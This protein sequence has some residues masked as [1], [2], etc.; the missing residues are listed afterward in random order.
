MESIASKYE[1]IDRLSEKHDVFLVKNIR[2]GSFYVEKDLSFYALDVYCYLRQNHIDHTPYIV[3]IEQAD[4]K[5]IVIEEYISGVSLADKIASE[6]RISYDDSLDYIRQLCSIVSDMHSCEPP[7]IHRDIKPENIIITSSGEVVL[8]DMNAAKFFVENDSADTYLLGTHGYAA[9]E[10][11]GFGK[12][13]ATSDIYGI[14]KVL[15]E[16]ITGS[17]K[18]EATG[19]IKTIIDKCTEIDSKKRYQSINELLKDL[20]NRQV[21]VNKD[22]NKLPGFRSDKPI[23]KVLAVLGYS[24]Y[25]FF[26]M[27]S[28]FEGVT[29]TIQKYCYRVLYGSTFLVCFLVACN[30]RYSLNRFGIQDSE[31]G[32]IRVF[33]MIIVVSGLLIAGLLSG[34]MIIEALF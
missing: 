18:G 13:N 31:K 2:T 12:A 27:I 28:E 14:G 20:N 19:S 8:L 1:V 32:V 30:Y 33:K 25:A 15:N 6:G 26:F 17:I 9:P 11:Y 21:S 3:E 24:L 7:I 34:N 10:Q 29:N 22:Y 16:M 5:L 23:I 4:D